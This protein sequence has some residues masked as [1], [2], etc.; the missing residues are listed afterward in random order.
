ML[1]QII[2]LA[3]ANDSKTSLPLAVI[4]LPALTVCILGAIGLSVIISLRHAMGGG[5]RLELIDCTFL[6]L[7]VYFFCSIANAVA[8]LLFICGVVTVV[9]VISVVAVSGKAFLGALEWTLHSQTCRYGADEDQI[10]LREGETEV[11]LL[12]RARWTSLKGEKSLL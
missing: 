10:T 8:L 7:L 12:G 4:A 9:T 5:K 11:F 3:V 6:Q 2:L 1:V